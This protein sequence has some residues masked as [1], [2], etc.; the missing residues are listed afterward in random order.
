MC[1]ALNYVISLM[2]LILSVQR[3]EVDMIFILQLGSSTV[4]KLSFLS[5]GLLKD[6]FWTGMLPALFTARSPMYLTHPKYLFNRFKV[7]PERK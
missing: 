3:L 1:W 7:S 4:I 2:Y 6:I 5:S